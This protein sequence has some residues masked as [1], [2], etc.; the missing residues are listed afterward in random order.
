MTTSNE[1]K[2]ELLGQPIGTATAKLRKSL[3]YEMAVLLD[4]HIC[5][6]CEQP[7]D[8]IDQFSIE[9]KKAWASAQ[10]PLEAFFD[11]TNIA[12]SHHACNVGAGVRPTKSYSNEQERSR[13]N[14]AKYYERHGERF[15]AAK[16][17]RY[18]RAKDVAMA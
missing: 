4:W 11:L 9:H 2:R 3:M 7:I 12:F 15:L 14:F 16:R 5:Y 10:D 13:A 18:H 1:R 17:D 6:R 8:D